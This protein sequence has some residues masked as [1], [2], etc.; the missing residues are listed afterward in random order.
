MQGDRPRYR[1]QTDPP[2]PVAFAG[3]LPR[4]EARLRPC[5]A[6]GLVVEVHRASDIDVEVRYDHHLIAVHL[7]DLP[8]LV[9]R[10][11][12]R[13]DERAIRAGDVVIT[14]AG[15]PKR[16]QHEDEARFIA[17][18][19]PHAFLDDIAAHA[20]Y[21]R[22]RLLDHW[23]VRDAHLE[24][25]VRRLA[26]ELSSDDRG[27]AI[28]A[29]ALAMQ[30][31]VQL[32]RRHC[33]SADEHAAA[34]TAVSPRKLRRAKE[35]IED[36]LAEDL[37][38]ERLAGVLAMS[39]FH[40]AHAFK[41]AVG[42]APHRFVLKCRVDRAMVMLRDTDLP[43]GDVGSR[44]GIPNPSHFSVVFRRLTGLPPRRFRSGE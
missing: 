21:E 26:E 37:T 8:R 2:V 27:G 3:R 33:A 12:G 6:S 34:A 15:A 10:R 31:A 14:P 32:L 16:W 24:R 36:H 25:L 30:I 28:Y 1:L 39:P 41:H 20:G 38:L 43:I 35:Y 9:Q 40:F 18:R 22:P 23:A 44:V 19:V 17:V 29:E 4:P 13:V 7:A 11:E 42:V 5:P